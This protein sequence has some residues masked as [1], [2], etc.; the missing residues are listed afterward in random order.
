MKKGFYSIGTII[1]LLMAAFIFVLVPAFSGG[2]DNSLPDYG[3]YDGKP[4][5]YVEGTEFHTQAMQQVQQMEYNGYDLSGPY[6]NFY[7]QMA[8]SQAFRTVVGTQAFID[9][10]ESTGWI[11]SQKATNRML[12]NF[13]TDEFGEYSQALY[14]NTSDDQ[15][16]KVINSIKRELNATRCYEDLF[17]GDA[18]RGNKLFGLKTSKNEIEFLRKMGTDLH[19]FDMVSFEMSQFPD[20][21][22]ASFGEQNPSLFVK[23]NLSVI[24]CADE[25]R[26]KEAFK[27]ISGNEI[28]FTDAVTSY[29]D[30]TYGDKE[31]G[32]ISASYK[33]QLD[34]AFTN[35]EDL[36]TVI[37]LAEGSTSNV[38]KTASGYSIFHIDAAPVQPDFANEDCLKNTYSYLTTRNK[39][40][41]E[42]Y[43]TRIAKD[44]ATSA[45]KDGFTTACTAANVTSVAVPAMALNFNNTTMVGKVSTGADNKIQQALTNENFLKTAFSLKKDGISEPIVLSDSNVVIVLRCTDIT[46]G[47]TSA[48]EAPQLFATEIN[49]ADQGAVNTAVQTSPK[50][51]DNS[52]AFM[53]A[54]RGA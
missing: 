1:I 20:S 50:I 3:K 13:F 5:R 28:T 25:S 32:K 17:G 26:A 31:T 53:K 33:F 41:I 9:F 51:Q 29:S 42:D 30:K 15:K 44:F 35:S 48:E 39:G 54:F 12:K 11:P 27:R 7:Y 34:N 52:K 19:S 49:S 23:Y 6:A 24:T 40:Y 8:F 38:I 22:I 21:E 46:Q 10:T 14:I 37:S 2:S 45:S 36:D 43:F 47:G 4:I 16:N 18:I